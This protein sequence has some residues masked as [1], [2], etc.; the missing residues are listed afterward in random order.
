M[1]ACEIANPWGNFESLFCLRN[2]RSGT[3]VMKLTLHLQHNLLLVYWEANPTM[4]NGLYLQ[5][6]VHAGDFAA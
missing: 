5:V 1:R 3:Q 4:L 6:R 2:S